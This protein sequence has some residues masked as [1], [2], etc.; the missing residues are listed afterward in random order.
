MKLLVMF[1]FTL[2]SQLI[3]F[4]VSVPVIHQDVKQA[5]TRGNSAVIQ[6]K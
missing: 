6:G 3:C 1:G 2:S 5:E 4:S